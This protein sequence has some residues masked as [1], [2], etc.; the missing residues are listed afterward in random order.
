MMK[1]IFRNKITF[2]ASNFIDFMQNTETAHFDL[3]ETDNSTNFTTISARFISPFR[4][5]VDANANVFRW[6]G[7]GALEISSL[8]RL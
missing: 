4:S 3:I 1:W 2:I 6:A 7:T 8:S 5:D